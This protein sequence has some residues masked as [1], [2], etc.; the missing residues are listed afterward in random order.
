MPL[1]IATFQSDATPPL[2][3]TLCHG[4][5]PPAKRIV[6]R[7]SARGI[8]LLGND[9]PIVLC[10]VDWVAIAG[11]SHDAW[12]DALAVAVGT[13]RER[14]AVHTLHQHDAPGT[15]HAVAELLA[16][17]GLGDAMFDDAFEQTAIQA[18]AAAAG[19]ACIAAEPVSHI[20]LGKARV[21][22][23]ASNRRLL[24]P[25]GTVQHVRYSSCRDAAIRAL[26]EGLIDPFVR[27]V[28]FWRGER[29]V[30]VLTY[31]ATHP[32]SF[33][34]RGAV[35]ADTVGLAR[36]LREATVPDCVHIHFNGA[37]GNVA[38]G[39]YN[40]GSPPKRLRLA[41]RLAEGMAAAWENA[42]RIPVTAEDLR[43]HV[44]P[45]ALP[46]NER[47]R[48]GEAEL[49]AR[50]GD[51]NSPLRERV[52]AAR[53]MAYARRVTGGHQVDIACLELGPARV[54]HMPG[55]LFV[56]YQLAAQEERPDLFVC[57]AAYGDDGMCYIGTH[58]AYAQGGYE[59]SRSCARV[60]P[61]VEAVLN[62]AVHALL[63]DA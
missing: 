59:C 29:P 24:G 63:H 53:E 32:Q 41:E 48:N 13:T 25:D 40:D 62:A 42:A 10:A 43:W 7:L 35:S 57:M 20:A 21:S 58:D 4:N 26:D 49:Q 60:S 28:A 18:A 14:V 19:T 22:H 55:E 52:F 6:D 12:R 34:G 9:A 1:H 15:D 2:G 27:Q 54:L 33:Y 38:A 3:A 46:L 44:Q 30:A 45:A 50:L 56:E 23:F 5:C 39:K 37:G 61:D 17:L 11:A 47:L 31:Y 36:A 51:A 8:I 16:P